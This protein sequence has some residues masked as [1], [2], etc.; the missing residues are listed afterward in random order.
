M[1]TMPRVTAEAV[2]DWLAAES[3]RID[4]TEL[5]SSGETNSIRLISRDG[6]DLFVKWREDAIEEFFTAEAAGLAAL[7]HRQSG[8]GIPQVQFHNE[9]V[10]AMD[11]VATKHA[12]EDDW[13]ALG[14][15]LARLHKETHDEFGFDIDTFCGPTRQYN[16]KNRDGF[17]FF[18]EQ[19]LLPLTEIARNKGLLQ[20]RDCKAIEILCHQLPSL[21][22]PQLARLVHGDLWNGNVLFAQS[23]TPV[24]IDPA[25]YWGWAE[26]ELAMTVLFGGFMEAFYSE[27]Q[28]HSDIDPRWRE[29]VDIYNLYPLLNHLVLFGAGYCSAVTHIL[30]PFRS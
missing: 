24:L 4:R 26:A 25:T 2:A 9:N 27:Y 21:I 1:T 16:K 29:R 10:I 20:R 7:K 11:Y 28:N 14:A 22:P 17:Q 23:G 18:A 30:T 15:G 6:R 13:Q 8:L 3:D 12:T 19:R 5:L